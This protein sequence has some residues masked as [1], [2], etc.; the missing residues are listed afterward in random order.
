MQISTG[1]E[2][3]ASSEDQYSNN[4]RHIMVQL[5]QRQRTTPARCVRGVPATVH[6]RERHHYYGLRVL[7]LCHTIV[8]MRFA[9]FLS[10]Y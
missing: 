2:C 7:N 9:V 3:A 6:F 5:P 4:F 10:K 8:A 1:I